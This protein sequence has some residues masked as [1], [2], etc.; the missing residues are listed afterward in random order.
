MGFSL[1]MSNARE[2]IS[3]VLGP[4]SPDEQSPATLNDRKALHVA[5]NISVSK[6]WSRRNNINL[7]AMKIY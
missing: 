7:G 3:I 1:S 5:I 6:M 4:P 2:A